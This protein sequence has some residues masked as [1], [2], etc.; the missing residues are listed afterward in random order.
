MPGVCYRLVELNMT[1]YVKNVQV[2][3]RPATTSRGETAAASTAARLAA[4]HVAAGVAAADDVAQRWQRR[5]RHDGFYSHEFVGVVT[6]I[7][8]LFTRLLKR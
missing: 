4:E 6:G 2:H 3:S 7:P 8:L 5:P 1:K